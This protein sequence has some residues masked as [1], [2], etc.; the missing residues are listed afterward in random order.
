[1]KLRILD[2]SVKFSVIILISTVSFLWSDDRISEVRKV[3]N[4]D[5][6]HLTGSGHLTIVQGNTE[7]LEVEADAELM[8][9]IKTEV[10]NGTL[11]L[12]LKDRN[13]RKIFHFDK[14]IHYYLTLKDLKK[15]RLSG[16]GD[17]ESDHIKSD[18]LSITISGSGEVEIADLKAEDLDVEISGSGECYLR[19]KVPQQSV[20]ISGSADYVAGK[21]KSEYV[22]VTV[23]GSGDATVWAE[24]E[25]EIRVSGSGDVDYYGYPRISQRVSGSGD[26]RQLG[27]K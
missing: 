17:I 25:L 16:S 8:R 4:F 15:L 19:G 23:S 9:Y 18:K 11:V 3:K 1:M 10:K 27:K 12:G 22:D 5:A 7:S 20:Y 26:I 24:E 14:P 6:V 2:Q 13:W 21:L